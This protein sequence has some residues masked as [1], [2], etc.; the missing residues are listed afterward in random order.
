MS[1]DKIK[2]MVNGLPGNMASRIAGVLLQKKEFE[3]LPLSLTEEGFIYSFYELGE[4]KF[5]MITP[6]SR[7]K[8]V[9]MLAGTSGVI[10]VD[11]TVPS[12][13]LGNVDF[14]CNQGFNFVLGTTGGDRGKIE[15]IVRDSS[16]SGVVAPNMAG[17]IVAFQA[18]IRYASENFP[19]LF[20]GYT[21]EITESHQQGKK[22]VSGTARAMLGDFGRLG[23]PL[24]VKDIR[25]IRDPEIQR[26]MGVP[27]EALG[28]HAWHT[29]TIKSKN[30]SVFF[31]FT[32]NINGR[33]VYVKGTELA[34]RYLHRKVGEGN[35]GKVYSMLDVLK[36]S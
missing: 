18:M 21:L 25:S 1:E 33:E 28:G 4:S 30:G 32:H 29:Y 13:V 24:E 6:S 14:Y 15:S 10:A 16:V 36:N 19:D 12:A 27:E 31:E 5:R 34:T 2:V 11:F 8:L 23:L 26:G 9:D 22:D 20:N 35:R 17:E 7:N 3:V